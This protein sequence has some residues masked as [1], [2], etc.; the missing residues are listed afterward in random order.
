M[1]IIAVNAGHYLGEDN[2]DP[3]A[4]N[5][6][7]GLKE[8]EIN[9]AVAHKVE[10]ILANRGHKVVYIHAGEL[11]EI[12]DASN[13]AGA[14]VFAS[15]HCNSA[16]DPDA[17]GV[18]TFACAGSTEGLKLAKL[19][20]KQLVACLGLTDRTVKTNG[21]YVTRNTDAIAILAEIGFISNP[22]EATQ[23]ATEQFQDNAAAAIAQGI[24]DY[25][26]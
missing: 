21:L 6:E 8:A 15:I 24:L 23:M 7:M 1:S 5:E 12:T 10:Q 26:C 20:Q 13:T 17:H 9:V 2:Y 22:E 14:D 19:V 25:L 11:N 16:A 3:G 4:C 18:E